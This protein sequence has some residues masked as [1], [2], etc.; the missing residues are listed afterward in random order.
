MIDGTSDCLPQVTDLESKLGITAHQMSSAVMTRDQQIQQLKQ[1]LVD[2]HELQPMPLSPSSAAA[3]EAAE[4]NL[5]G[6]SSQL[7][8]QHRWGWME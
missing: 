4:S 5:A 6:Q 8:Q 7:T 3:V 1:K 2:S